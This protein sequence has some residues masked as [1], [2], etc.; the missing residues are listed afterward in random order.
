M[1]KRKG[2]QISWENDK[3]MIKDDKEDDGLLIEEIWLIYAS[4]MRDR[5][6]IRT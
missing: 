3:R 2:Q 4:L 6:R 1:I 5:N